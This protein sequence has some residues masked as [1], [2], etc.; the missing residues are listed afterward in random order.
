MIL[1]EGEVLPRGYGLVRKCFDRLGWE[2]QPI[3]YHWLKRL[4]YW[5]REYHI[6]A[7]DQRI[8][9]FQ[10]DV[11]TKGYKEG[12]TAAQHEAFNVL[13]KSWK[14]NLLKKKE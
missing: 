10:K 11:Y 9:A 4:Y 12:F 5:V 3:G 14:S 6:T 8:Y 7:A 13:E 1:L 2:V